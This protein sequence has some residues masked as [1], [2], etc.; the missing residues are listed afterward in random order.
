MR[1]LSLSVTLATLFCLQF[2]VGPDSQAQE[3]IKQTGER[4]GRPIVNYRPDDPWTRGKVFNLQTGHAGLFHN[5]DGEECKRNSPYICWKRDYEKMFPTPLGLWGHTK[6]TYT[7]VKQRIRDGAGACARDCTCSKCQPQQ[8]HPQYVEQQPAPK[9]GKMFVVGANA[10]QSAPETQISNGTSVERVVAPR[11]GLIHGK[12]MDTP[13]SNTT[14]SNEAPAE[15]A[16][17]SAASQTLPSRPLRKVAG[18][19]GFERNLRNQ[20]K[21]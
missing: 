2:C 20:K 11:F 12:I 9:F 8:Q 3:I 18:R 15:I 14:A 10:K 1:S 7:D 17:S 6:K 19:N 13:A 16:S 21:R 5:C 4:L